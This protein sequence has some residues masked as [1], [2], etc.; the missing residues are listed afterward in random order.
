MLFFKII[1]S[2]K[3]A[4]PPLLCLVIAAQGL[5]LRFRFF[6]GREL[7]GDERFQLA[8]MSG[9]FKMPWQRHPYGDFTCFPGD[10]L[11]SYPFVRL[12]EQYQNKWI[13]VAPHIFITVIGFFLLYF[14]CRG[15]FKTAGGYLVAFLVFSLNGEL[16]FHAF[17]FRP[18]AVLPVLAMASFYFGGIVIEKYRDLRMSGKYLLGIFFVLMIWFHLYG[19][20]MVTVSLAFLLITSG[21]AKEFLKGEAR[22]VLSY[23]ML[24]YAVALPLWFWYA[25]RPEDPR[26][27]IDH[28]YTF[29]YIPHPLFEP[30]GFLKGIFGNLF[31]RGDLHFLLTGM[32]AAFVLPVDKKPSQIGFFLLLIVLPLEL[33]CLADLWFQYPFMQRQFIWVV[34]YFA[35]LL[36]WQWDSVLLYAKE[37]CQTAK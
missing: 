31:G 6:A 24:I 29:T 4:A 11:L 10:Y 22:D 21:K 15:Y 13:L 5:Y 19:I 25:L 9:P 8:D 20:L 36:G 3:K 30:V 27:L 1:D 37:K 33:I 16:I 26:W 17:E 28:N 32:V 18:Y 14:I 7:T 2:L 34:P 23:L 35:F 12:F